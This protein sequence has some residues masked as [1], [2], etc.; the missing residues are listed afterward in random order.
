M[1]G[2]EPESHDH[3]PDPKEVEAFKQRA[4]LKRAAVEHLERPPTRILRMMQDLPFGF[5]KTSRSIK[6]AKTT[7]TRTFKEVPSTPQSLADPLD[8]PDKY[9]KTVINEK[10]LFYDSFV[11]AI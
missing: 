7:S 8:I 3:V 5:S 11:E 1:F 9:T 2:G 4:N 6:F 10:F